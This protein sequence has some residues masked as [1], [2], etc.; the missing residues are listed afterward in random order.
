MKS[1][2]QSFWSKF[3]SYVIDLKTIE[4][5]CLHPDTETQRIFLPMSDYQMLVSVWYV[6]VVAGA[7]Q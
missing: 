4:R 7:I 6:A 5:E 3:C 2:E 1:I